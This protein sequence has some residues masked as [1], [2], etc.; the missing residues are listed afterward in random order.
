MSI[1]R[2]S[3]FRLFKYAVYA[4]LALNVYLF[5]DEE[6]AAAQ[7][8]FPGGVSFGALIEAYAATIDTA[9]WL[10][11]L[12]LFETETDLLP[13]EYFTRPVVWALHG[14]RI[15]CYSFIVYAFYG[16]IVNLG[17]VTAAQIAPAVTD[18]C[19]VVDGTW[20]YGVTLDRYEVL[21]DANCSS[22]PALG[23]YYQYPGTPAV[24]NAHDLTEIVRLAWVDVINAGVWLLVVLN[25][26]LDVRLQVHR[27][28]SGIV[29]RVSNVSKF[30]IYSILFL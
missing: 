11:L 13:D 28:F 14:L 3:V 24:S 21:T 26:E 7:L 10:V 8:Q 12:L 16:Y 29:L 23:P 9:A 27:K 2:F 18:L 25:L 5:F 1:D 19:A 4:L 6:W 22:F 30:V 17:F 15:F 20:S